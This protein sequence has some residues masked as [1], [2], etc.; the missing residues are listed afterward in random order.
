MFENIGEAESS[1]SGNGSGSGSGSGSSG[2]STTFVGTS[3]ADSEDK[4][5][6][7][8]A[9]KFEGYDGADI[10][11]GGSGNDV[12]WGA[13]GNDTLTGNAGQDIF[14]FQDF[15]EGK[16]TISDFVVGASG[17]ALKFGGSFTSAYTRDSTLVDDNGSTGTTYNMA[18]NSNV[19]PKI[20]NFT[21]AFATAGSTSGVISQLTSFVVTTD[22]T[23]PISSSADFIVIT[24]TTNDSFVYGWGD[25]GN[26][27]I[28]NGELFTLATLTG[29]DNDS[30]TASNFAFG[31]I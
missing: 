1:E 22:G 27:S 8:D 4:S 13:L 19:L 28:D 24:S 30:M 9:W 29:V 5:A 21:D 10:F 16:D 15:T 17:D 7:S 2:S 25:S 18:T 20:F 23:N 11:K 6:E 14:Y 31:S 3:A 26:G 12:F